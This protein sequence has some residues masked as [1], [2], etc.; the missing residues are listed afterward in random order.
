MSTIADRI[1]E[2]MSDAAQTEQDMAEHL[3]VA[4]STIT[5]WLN[6]QAT[7][8]VEQLLALAQHFGVDLHQLLT[9]LDDHDEA[10]ETV[11]IS[12]LPPEHARGIDILE[13]YRS[14][15]TPMQHARLARSL[16]FQHC[17]KA[18]AK[19]LFLVT[20]YG[21]SMEPTFK[22]GDSVIIDVSEQQIKGDALY[23]IKM[24]PGIYLKRIQVLLGEKC[25]IISDNS[26][27]QNF[28]APRDE[29]EVLGRVVISLRLGSS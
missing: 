3:N 26:L 11:E 24:G 15:R 23:V 18:D 5:Q 19:N 13:T 28:E 17:P 10:D 2:L 6:G 12:L 9:G 16:L 25:L 21:D 22:E 8:T 20:C 1:H 29:I 7:P 4:P 27:Y 14:K